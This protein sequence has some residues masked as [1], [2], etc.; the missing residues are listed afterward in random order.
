M[1]CRQFQRND[2]SCIGIGSLRQRELWQL[3]E[4]PAALDLSRVSASAFGHVSPRSIDQPL[5]RRI[6]RYR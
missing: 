2:D 1:F 6:E 3:D 4:F 5:C